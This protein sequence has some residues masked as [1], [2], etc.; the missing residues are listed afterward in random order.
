MN[1]NLRDKA[2]MVPFLSELGKALRQEG[3]L[4]IVYTLCT[5]SNIN[6]YLGKDFLF[7]FKN[8][9]NN[10]IIGDYFSNVTDFVDFFILEGQFQA[11]TTDPKISLGCSLKVLVSIKEIT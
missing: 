2:K 10:K 7:N 1:M 5:D 4:H 9:A 11:A 6:F 3:K 8:S